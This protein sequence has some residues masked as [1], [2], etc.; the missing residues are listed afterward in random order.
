M[1]KIKCD[2]TEQKF[3]HFTVLEPVHVEY[4]SKNVLRWKCLCECGNIFY[5]QTS[6]ITSQKIKS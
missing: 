6:A 1:R 2:L 3:P 5:A 4:K